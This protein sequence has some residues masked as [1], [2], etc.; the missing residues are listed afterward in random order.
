MLCQQFCLTGPMFE[1]QKTLVRE[2]SSQCIP[3]GF[4]LPVEAVKDEYV[5]LRVIREKRD[6]NT[7]ICNRERSS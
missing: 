2:K 4:F 3:D 7:F 1:Q 6:S 5:V